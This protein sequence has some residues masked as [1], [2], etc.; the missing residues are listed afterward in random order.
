VRT[1]VAIVLLFGACAAQEVLKFPCDFE[2]RCPGVDVCNIDS[3]LCERTCPT[4]LALCSFAC[5]DVNSDSKN[6][7]ACDK[8]CASSESCVS[9]SCQKTSMMTGFECL[10]CGPGVAC[11]N[12]KCDCQARGELCSE[13]FCIDKKQLAVSCGTCLTPCA[14]SGAL[15]RNGS[16]ECAAGESI[17]DGECKTTNVDLRC[18]SCTNKC[19]T[20]THCENGMCVAQCSN[21]S[22]GACSG[23]C[24]NVA[25]DPKHCG[26]NCRN[27]GKNSTCDAGVCGCAGGAVSCSGTCADVST[28]SLNCGTCGNKCAPG[29][30]CK[31]A[32][33]VCEIGLTLCS[34]KCVPLNE[35]GLNCGACGVACSGT[36]VCLSGKCAAS[37]QLGRERCEDG[38]CSGAAKHPSHCGGC[39]TVC[40]AGKSCF[41]GSCETIVPAPACTSCPCVS[42]DES[43][44]LCCLRDGKVGCFG[45]LRCPYSLVKI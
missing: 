35:D 18:G 45:G 41:D 15:C 26:P 5:V 43:R 21:N 33:C 38:T 19:A 44:N 1:K 20:G 14:T 36:S 37:C 13:S 24:F 22:T 40:S 23:Q 32:E 39:T 12:Q 25:T 30:Q 28:D 27:C 9:G 17:C 2:G 7:G 16:C 34:A 42:C 11:I 8:S 3:G 4:A 29:Q 31:A 6:C 10:G